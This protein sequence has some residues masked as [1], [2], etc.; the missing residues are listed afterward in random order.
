MRLPDQ[1]TLNAQLA[2]NFMP[3]FHKNVEAFVDV[4]NVLGLRTINAV[5]E[6]DGQDFG[7]PRGREGPLRF[8]LGVRYKY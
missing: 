6:I 8:R 5:G 3:L 4:L 2:F 1:Q 7:V